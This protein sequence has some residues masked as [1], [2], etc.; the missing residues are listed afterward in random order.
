MRKTDNSRLSGSRGS[1][2]APRCSFTMGFQVVVF[3]EGIFNSA[4]PPLSRR[5][6]T[7]TPNGSLRDFPKRSPKSLMTPNF[8]YKDTF[9]M[10]FTSSFHQVEMFPRAVTYRIRGYMEGIGQCIK[11]L[12]IVKELESLR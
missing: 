3:N 7:V 2:L 12:P 4:T 6:W 9:H 10:T 5:E 11:F 1:S 8:S